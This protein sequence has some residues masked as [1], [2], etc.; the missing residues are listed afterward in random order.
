MLQR[1]R[2][3]YRKCTNRVEFKPACDSWTIIQGLIRGLRHFQFPGGGATTL[4]QVCQQS[5]ELS[6]NSVNLD[7]E[8]LEDIR[9]VCVILVC[10]SS[11]TCCCRRYED[12]TTIDWIQD[13][14]LERNRRIRHANEVYASSHRG[15]HGEITRQWLR[16]QLRKAVDAGQTWF[17]VSL[18]G[19]HIKSFWQ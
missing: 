4:C 15:P 9:F 18:V 13:S 19:E 12:F 16:A 5:D 6:M 14:I 11:W 1:L 3:I 8:E 2:R 17:V 7:H 10:E